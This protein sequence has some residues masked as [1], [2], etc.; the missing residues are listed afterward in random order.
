[1]KIG[2][3]T[4]NC[5][6]VCVWNMVGALCFCEGERLSWP[7]LPFIYLFIYFSLMLNLVW[8]TSTIAL[9]SIKGIRFVFPSAK[10]FQLTRL[11]IQDLT[12]YS[13]TLNTNLWMLPTHFTQ[14]RVLQRD[15]SSSFF[16]NEW[17]KKKFTYNIIFLKK[18]DFRTLHCWVDLLFLTWKSKD[19][20]VD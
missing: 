16:D 5:L 10:W 9:H 3:P 2:Q 15:L 4:R 1:M 8:T 14:G 13:I 11:L 18:R 17:K 20:L 19:F 12:M 7:L 6:L